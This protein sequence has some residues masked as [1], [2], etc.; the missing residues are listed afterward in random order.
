MGKANG[1]N[2][3][4]RLSP[5][6]PPSSVY[7]SPSSSKWGTI[8][9]HSPTATTSTVHRDARWL[10][11]RRAG[12]AP[13]PADSRMDRSMQKLLLLCF[14]PLSVLGNLST[15]REYEGGFKGSFTRAISLQILGTGHATIPHIKA[16]DVPFQMG[17]GGLISSKSLQNDRPK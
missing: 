3:A 13:A 10:L 5:V 9:L 11:T 14:N 2:Q 12:D 4:T 7:E 15:L 8:R 16:K 17:Y 6:S 1:V